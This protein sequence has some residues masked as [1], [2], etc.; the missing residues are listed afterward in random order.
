MIEL[1]HVRLFSNENE[2]I[3]VWYLMIGKIE[4]FLCWVLEDE[5]R[6]KKV[7]G[8]TRIPE[9]LYEITFRKEGGH[10]AKYSAKFP[11]MHKG[12]L[13]IIGV[14]NFKYI[15]FHIGNDEEDTAGCVLPGTNVQMRTKDSKDIFTITQS[16]AA[17]KR[18]YPLIANRLDVGD[19]CFIKVI[20][21]KSLNTMLKKGK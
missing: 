18:V 11:N 3:G 10:H 7:Y 4:Q 14:P 17:Y 1:K 20:D 9:G 6:N 21:D 8:E 13:H 15:L 12:M 5:F 19:K 2:T 16:T